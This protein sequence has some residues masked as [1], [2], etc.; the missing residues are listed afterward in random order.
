VTR[1]R[2]GHRPVNGQ[3][4]V[5][6]HSVSVLCVLG[7]NVLPRRKIGRKSRP[8]CTPTASTRTRQ[9]GTPPVQPKALRLSCDGRSLFGLWSPAGG[10]RLRTLTDTGADESP[11]R[12]KGRL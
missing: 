10:L 1:R 12:G 6:V 3:L 7:L 2:C 9:L 4:K 11:R 8:V 5:G